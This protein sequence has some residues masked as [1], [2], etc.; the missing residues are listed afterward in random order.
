MATS[1]VITK[2]QWAIDPAHTDVQFKVKHLVITTVTGTFQSF[3][4]SV[5]SENDDFDQADVSFSLEIGSISTNNADRDAHLKSDDFFN[6]ETYPQITFNNGILT[7]DSSGDYTLTGDL[8]I[9]ETTKKVS[10]DVEYG[11]TVKD[12]WGNTKAGFEISGKIN[13]K[14]FGLT[15]NATTEA[16][17]VLVGEEVKILINVQLSKA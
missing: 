17:G 1:E 11:G 8:T 3:S 2:Q 7:K 12:P 10:L 6:A 16:G 5:A 14:E 9:R 15:W 4:G 13:R